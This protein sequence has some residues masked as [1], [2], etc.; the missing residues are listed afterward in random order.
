MKIGCGRPV[1]GLG[2]MLE[3]STRLCWPTPGLAHPC[4][5]VWSGN[6]HS[7]CDPQARLCK[8]LGLTG[9]AGLYI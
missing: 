6:I 5:I 8:I 1:D 4:E 2:G 9:T 7:T 3:S